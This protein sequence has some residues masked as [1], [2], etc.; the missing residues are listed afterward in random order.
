[1]ANDCLVGF[2]QNITAGSMN[3]GSNLVALRNPTHSGTGIGHVDG[4]L[5]LDMLLGHKA[6]INCRTQTCFLQGRSGAPDEPQLLSRRRRNSPESRCVVRK[7]A[8]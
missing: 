1:M 2:V 8:R 6:V 7:V 5:G 3:F 4:V